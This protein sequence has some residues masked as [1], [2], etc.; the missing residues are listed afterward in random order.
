MRFVLGDPSSTF[1][2]GQKITIWILHRGGAYR[3]EESN[4]EWGGNV[5]AVDDHGI[6]LTDAYH[7]ERLSYVTG[8]VS[9]WSGTQ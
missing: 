9:C 3:E 6:R 1:R 5:A 2:V 8:V 4:H 7:E